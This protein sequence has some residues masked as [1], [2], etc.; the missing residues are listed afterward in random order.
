MIS[1][2]VHAKD[3][4]LTIFD[5][6]GVVVDSETICVGLLIEYLAKHDL[7]LTEEQAYRA[8]LGKQ[9][10][11]MDRSV[12]DNFG[13]VV[14]PLDEAK[15]KAELFER[16]NTHLKP[17][18]DID[19]AFSQI[20]GP[21]CIASS[22]SPDRIEIS[23]GI[24]GLNEVF[25]GRRFGSGTVKR[26]KPAPDLFLHAASEHGVSPNNCI[27][28]E[29]S[30]AGLTA[31]KAAGMKSIGFVGGSHAAKAD[32]VTRLSLLSPDL[33]IDNMKYLPAAILELRR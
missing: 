3:Q 30:T 8:F 4:H 5:F 21:M 14:P 28:I 7:G 27:V 11:A 33:I 9:I 20:S 17:I 10:G 25:T 32:L 1:P 24:T 26:G 16:F 2:A 29:D 22:S 19:W 23:L 18:P 13:T 15:F 6:D 12:L 31:A